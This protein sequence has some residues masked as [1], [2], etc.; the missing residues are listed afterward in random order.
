MVK[1]VK[2]KKD[3]EKYRPWV[4]VKCPHCQLPMNS[5]ECPKCG[6][7]ASDGIAAYKG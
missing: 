3:I 2:L 4:P 1:N 7:K 6:Y 5:N